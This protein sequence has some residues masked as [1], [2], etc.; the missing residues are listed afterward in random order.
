MRIQDSIL[1]WCLPRVV[2]LAIA[3]SFP[4]FGITSRVNNLDEDLICVWLRNRNV[5][6]GDLWALCNDCFLHLVC[7]GMS[8]VSLGCF[9]D[10]GGGVVRVTEAL[11]VAKIPE[12]D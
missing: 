5:M 2:R 10:R 4:I 6:N 3:R 8:E 1:Q 7:S 12:S 11:V 9:P